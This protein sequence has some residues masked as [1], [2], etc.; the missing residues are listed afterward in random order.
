MG[1]NSLPSGNQPATPT[2][3]KNP[4]L[5]PP[6]DKQETI[7]Q[8]LAAMSEELKRLKKLDTIESINIKLQSDIALVQSRVDAVSDKVNTVQSELNK[9]EKKWELAFN[10]LEGRLSKMEKESRSQDNKRELSR[11]SIAKDIEVL[12]SSIDSNSKKVIEMESFIQQSQEKWVSLHTLEGKIKIAADKKFRAVQTAIKDEVKRDILLTVKQDAQAQ[13]QEADPGAGAAPQVTPDDLKRLKVEIVEEVRSQ[14][15]ATPGLTEHESLRQ[16]AFSKRYNI[17]IFGLTDNDWPEQDYKEAVI[18]FRDQ[19][20]LNGLHILTTY[21]LGSFKPNSYAPRPLVVKFG[22]IRDRWSVWNCR[23]RIKY[24][25]HNPIQIQEDIPKKLRDDGR[26][27]QRIA[28]VANQSQY[29]IG[30]ARVKDHKVIING[31]KYGMEN[32]KNL[33]LHLQPEAAYTPRT[34]ETVVFF[35][36]NSPFSNHHI[37]PFHL[38]NQSFVSVEQ[39][40]AHS[41]AMMA[42]NKALA[43]KALEVED[44]AEH[45]AILNT[46]RPEIQDV[47][48]DRA[49]SIIL[50]A[51]RAKF[52]QNERL[53]NFLVETYPL[54]IGE[55]SR[56]TVWGTGLQLEHPD[57]MNKLK[58]E[59]RGNLLGYTPEQVR[60]ELMR[61]V[62]NSQPTR[63]I[64]LAS[65]GNK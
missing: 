58:W 24:N 12:Q 8:T 43:K 11:E 9:Y 4:P 46:L 29:S 49:P 64:P 45:K 48:E 42:N 26:I 62:L 6:V 33:P 25:K 30:H 16:Q 44:P 36:K 55:A 59:T 15:K 27:L 54:S 60:E 52:G 32:L 65:S 17:L 51:I 23:G 50:P 10:Q 57:V 21:R 13:A 63:V 5:P 20:G 18:F 19:M 53:A 40:L 31:T 2:G 56:D 14:D 34:S 47:W 7:L 3:G 39:Y 38:N 37:A 22:N 41:K 61:K 28:K 1:N 35:T